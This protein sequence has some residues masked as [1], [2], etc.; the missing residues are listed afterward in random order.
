MVPLHDIR[1]FSSLDFFV[2]LFFLTGEPLLPF[3]DGDF[4]SSSASS[5]SPSYSLF[6]LEERLLPFFGGD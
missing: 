5:S 6:L 2:V 3:L 1:R 4:R